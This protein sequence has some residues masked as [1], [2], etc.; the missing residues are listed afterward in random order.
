MS[1]VA[2][3]AVELAVRSSYGRLIAVLAARTGDVTAAEDALAEALHDALEQWPTA[4]VPANPEGWL[5]HVARRR[6]TDASRR[7]Q[8]RD[9]HADALTYAATL[10]GEDGGGGFPDRRLDLLFACAHPAID[11]TVRT[12]LMLQ[13]VLG[14]DADTVA[15]AFLASPATMAQRLVRAKRKIRDAGIRIVDLDEIERTA[16]VTWVLDALYAAFT[17]GWDA[18]DGSD[19]QRAD[20]S[21][22]AIWL[23]RLVAEAMPTHAEALGLLALMLHAHAR[24]AARRSVTGDYVALSAQDPSQWDVRLIA[25]A[26]ETLRRAS[27][28]AQPGRYQ[29]EAAIQSAHAVTVRG[30]PRDWVA[31]ATLYRGL[32]TVAPTVGALVGEAAA[33][34]EAYG[35]EAGLSALDALPTDAVEG[36]QPWWAL[37]GHVLRRLGRVVEADEA[38]ARAAGLTQDDAVRRFLLAQMG[39]ALPSA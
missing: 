32:V 37:R 34:N 14:L 29:L 3:R 39:S 26:E 1:E 22:E 15:S 6:I 31:I 28:L 5:V 33:L 20:L 9:H 18:V 23:A 11:I 25:E 4:G 10:A 17:A 24:R 27:V 21:D 30:R 2:R 38:T 16:R 35:A 13:V 12:P 36:Y 19:A 8:V 7:A